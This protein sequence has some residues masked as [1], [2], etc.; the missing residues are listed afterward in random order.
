VDKLSAG[1]VANSWAMA[2]DRTA[3]ASTTITTVA[4]PGDVA[5][6][7]DGDG[8]RNPWMQLAKWDDAWGAI[9][10]R[11]FERA[12]AARSKYGAGGDFAAL[13]LFAVYRSGLTSYRTIG[14]RAA[15]HDR[16]E[17]KRHR[18]GGDAFP[19]R[20]AYLR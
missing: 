3:V 20:R 17:S 19:R 12:C 4:V 16:G 1:M 9:R 10:Q 18:V 7:S 6:T 13:C 2:T 8:T 5:C 14:R 15:L 11:H